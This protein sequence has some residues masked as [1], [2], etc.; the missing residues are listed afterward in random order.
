[1]S[2]ASAGWAVFEVRVRQEP[3]SGDR[4]DLANQVGAGHDG[5]DAGLL[6]RR[7]GFDL[8]DSGVGVGTADESGVGEA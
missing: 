6:F 5:N 4:A 1:M 7:R 2:E 3:G 8:D